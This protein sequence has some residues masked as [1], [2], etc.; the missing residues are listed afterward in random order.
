MGFHKLIQLFS[1]CH[2][3]FS[4]NLAYYFCASAMLLEMNQ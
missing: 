1:P 4:I 2:I 3:K